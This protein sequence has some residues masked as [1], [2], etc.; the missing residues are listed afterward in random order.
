MIATAGLAALVALLALGSLGIG[1]VRLS[2]LTV[3]DA[4]FGG[5]TD[6]QRII[7]RRNSPSA[8]DPRIGNR[9][10]TR[11]VGRCPAGP[12]A[13]S[14]GV[15]FPVR[16]AAIGG[17]RRCADDRARLGRR[18]VLRAAGC[19]HHDGIRVGV[20][21]ARHRRKKR[22]SAVADSFRSGDFQS[23]GSRD[24]AGDEPVIQ[25]VCRARNRVLAARLAGG[26]QLPPCHARACRSSSQEPSS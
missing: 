12:A 7:V 18:P 11:P 15:A 5:G 1:P 17:I 14:A 8:N 4:L 13:Q 20:R 21:A 2:P 16:R 24:R 23:C 10:D 22:G 6:I 3:I 26:P 9:R 19:R 25:S